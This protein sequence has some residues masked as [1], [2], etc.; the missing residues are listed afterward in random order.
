MISSA[1]ELATTSKNFNDAISK[2]QPIINKMVEDAV[3]QSNLSP[4][5][6]YQMMQQALQGI[7][8]PQGSTV[9]DFIQAAPPPQRTF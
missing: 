2:A 3:K 1:M 4:D 9:N 8:L 5:A 6:V 7:K